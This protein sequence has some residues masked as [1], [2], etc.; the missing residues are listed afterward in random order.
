MGRNERLLEVEG[1]EAHSCGRAV[2]AGARRKGE[3]A[4]DAMACRK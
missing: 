1:D 3:T 4:S 2:P